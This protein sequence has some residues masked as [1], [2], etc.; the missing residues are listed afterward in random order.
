MDILDTI[1]ESGIIAISRG[2]YGDDLKYTVAALA[3]AGIRAFE[4]TFEQ[5]GNI[6]NTAEAIKMLNAEFGESC[7]IGAGTVL[8]MEQLSAAR[9][10]GAEYIISPNVDIEIVGTTKKMGIVSIPGAMTPTEIISAHK[11]GA[12]IVKLFP[13]GT[14]GVSYFKAVRAPLSHIRLAAVA[15]VTLENIADFKKAGACCF[16][17]SSG[18]FDRTLIKNGE[19]DEVERIAREYLMRIGNQ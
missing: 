10:A 7:A 15:G 16:G 4:V 17:I 12:D 9:Y 6:D 1:L 11:A 8:T 3:R 2:F 19:F 18:L 13:A 5:N 14:L